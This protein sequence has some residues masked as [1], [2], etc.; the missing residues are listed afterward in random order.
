MTNRTTALTNL[1]SAILADETDFTFT[2]V[3][4]FAENAAANAD[5][6]FVLI[7]ERREAYNEDT[8]QTRRALTVT[9]EAWAESDVTVEN[10]SETAGKLLAQLENSVTNDRTLSA[11]AMTLE[12]V[13]NEV[14]T[15]SE[16][17]PSIGVFLEI[18]IRYN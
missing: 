14:F 8:S 13:G 1:A 12:L 5:V 7:H 3:Q 2:K 6:P 15:A 9:L 17:E 11:S 10:R 4:R 18:L 16:Q